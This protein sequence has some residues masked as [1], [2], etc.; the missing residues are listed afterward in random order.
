MKLNKSGL[1]LLLLL[2]FPNFFLE[3]PVRNSSELSESETGTNDG[4]NYPIWI[5]VGV[6]LTLILVWSVL[7]G[8]WL[9]KRHF[10]GSYDVQKAQAKVLFKNDK[11]YKLTKTL[12]ICII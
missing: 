12:M 10:T 7:V 8:A 5:G 3:M 1:L 2:I 11:C 6:S 9:Y 4:S